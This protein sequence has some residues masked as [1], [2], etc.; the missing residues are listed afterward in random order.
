MRRRTRAGFIAPRASLRFARLD[1]ISPL[2]PRSGSFAALGHEHARRTGFS[3]RV[4]GG[5]T[6]S[7][8]HKAV[9]PCE[10]GGSI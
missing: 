10:F 5:L 1:P 3:E 8:S 2:R 9:L 6:R 4:E 7:R